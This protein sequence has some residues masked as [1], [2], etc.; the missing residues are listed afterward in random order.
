MDAFIAMPPRPEMS[1]TDVEFIKSLNIPSLCL[2]STAMDYGLNGISTDF[3]LGGMMAA[4]HLIKLGHTKLAFLLSHPATSD[5]EAM[6][7]GFRRH[8]ILVGINEPL[9]IDSK[10]KPGEFSMR[11]AFNAISH[12]LNEDK[13][14]FTGLFCCSDVCAIA[15]MSACHENGVR[16]PEDV[17]IIGFNGEPEWEFSV[18]PLTTLKHDLD[19]WVAAA[20][21]MIKENIRDRK[22]APYTKLVIPRLLI[23]KSSGKV[24]A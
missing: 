11:S 24:P 14:K 19:G 5:Y 4:E 6:Y 18:P 10:I 13:G 1:A 21:E 9:F 2:S 22:R 15:T 3:E 16:I 17:S 12:L 8:A 23:R 20:I 7:K